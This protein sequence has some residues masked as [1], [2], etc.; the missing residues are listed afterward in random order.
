MKI[1]V[2]RS[3][4]PTLSLSLFFEGFNSLFEYPNI[5]FL[6]SLIENFFSP[7]TR[8]PKFDEIV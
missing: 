1:I 4:P 5:A 8:L 6:A 7:L 2:L 3:V